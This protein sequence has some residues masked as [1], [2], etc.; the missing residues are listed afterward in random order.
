VYRIPWGDRDRSAF[1]VFD[2]NNVRVGEADYQIMREG[3]HFVLDHTVIVSTSQDSSRLRL[4]AEDLR[5]LEESRTI[6]QPGAPLQIH[7]ALEGTTLTSR[8]VGPGAPAAVTMEVPKGTYLRAQMPILVRCLRFAK[9]QVVTLSVFSSLPP[10]VSQVTATVVGKEQVKTPGGSFET[11]K[12][13]VA[14]PDGQE[15]Y[16]CDTAG[17]HRLRK[18]TQ[19][20]YTYL[21]EETRFRRLAPLLVQ[22]SAAVSNSC[23]NAGG[24]V[25]VVWG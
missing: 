5:P 11:W 12:V 23:I 16:W 2:E 25:V 14:G 13:T 15:I 4:R 3:D 24:R 21:S 19:G 1:T 17:A 20:G 22:V 9:G 18:Y 6:T 7:T 10:G 8:A